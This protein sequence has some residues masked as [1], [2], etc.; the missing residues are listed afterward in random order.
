M[1]V[2]SLVLGILV[3][4]AIYIAF[5]KIH[6][7]QKGIFAF[8]A[9]AM[10]IAFVCEAL[11][12]NYVVFDNA[13]KGLTK[14]SYEIEY[15]NN[16][17]KANSENVNVNKSND[18]TTVEIND[19]NKKVGNVEIKLPSNVANAEVNVSYKDE[20]FSDFKKTS[21]DEVVVQKDVARSEIIRLHVVGKVQAL[22]LEIKSKDT[23]DGG[24]I[25]HE[26]GQNIE[27]GVMLINL[28]AH[29][30]FQ[31][32]TAR[33]LVMILLAFCAL[34]IYEYRDYK[35]RGKKSQKVRRTA[36]IVLLAMQIVFLSFISQSQMEDGESRIF[37]RLDTEVSSGLDQYHQ[38]TLALAHG[39][40]HL[41]NI[42]PGDKNVDEPQLAALKELDKQ[43]KT[44][45][46]NDRDNYVKQKGTNYRWDEAYYNG[47]YY[48][49]YGP[50]PVVLVF[51]PVY[52]ITGCLLTTRFV[53]LLLAVAI[54]ALMARLVYNIAKRREG[55]N[56][57]TVIGCMAM[58]MSTVFVTSCFM[59]AKI[60]ELSPMSGLALVLGGINC[61]YR[62]LTE[63]NSKPYLWIVGAICMALSVGC[64][65]TFAFA[66]LIVGIS[67]IYYLFKNSKKD[68]EE[69]NAVTAFFQKVFSKENIKYIAY[70]AIPYVVIG[71]LLMAYNYG[72]F[73]SPFDF[74]VKYQL[75][76]FNTHY[77]SLADLSK[78]P[79]AIY[80]GLLDM[81]STMSTFPFLSMQNAS[82]QYNGYMFTMAGV[83]MLAY[84]VM[85]LLFAM[86][87]ATKQKMLLTSNKQ[88][89]QVIDKVTMISCLLVGLLSCYASTAMGGTSFRYALDYGWAFTISLVFVVFAI[90]QWANTNNVSK[91]ANKVIIALILVTIII[92]ILL[93]IG[94]GFNETVNRH[95]DVYYNM[96]HSIM[97]WK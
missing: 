38:L 20:V 40:L 31:I 52:L 71:V 49:Y 48:T 42:L 75:T 65:P 62:A 81:P 88:K 43:G 56:M 73:G 90:A 45:S 46:P 92:N 11:V 25:E 86:P 69:S 30:P 23:M 36:I 80:N 5:F 72:R 59:G 22:K 87:Y 76:L 47:H 57:W 66:S 9:A 8:I 21:S 61:F 67:I 14:S 3:S 24:I 35:F 37:D 91:Y 97:F 1:G 63:K 60:Y 28:N 13:G 32:N 54:S 96:Y 50:V 58:A 29:V 15:A 51:L 85:W 89:G 33:V 95:P 7:D 94:T 64:K 39:Q 4:V 70:V 19:I 27:N 2:A 12:F 78:L 82:P 17:P 26:G 18:L 77:Y 16:Q 55:L 84:P 79:V 10:M 53:T 6:L 93:T 74:G 41:D 44:Y 68:T 34:C 83:G